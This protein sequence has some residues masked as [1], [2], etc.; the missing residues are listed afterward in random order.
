MCGQR[1]HEGHHHSLTES[2][3][4]ALGNVEGVRVE[5]LGGGRRYRRTARVLSSGV[6][7]KE[8]M[9][10]RLGCRFYVLNAGGL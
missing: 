9:Y 7:A 5:G 8:A 4:L 10:D 1:P 6:A 2:Y 3:C